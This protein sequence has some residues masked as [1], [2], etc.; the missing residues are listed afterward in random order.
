MVPFP[1]M[2]GMR[3][4]IR[5]GKKCEPAAPAVNFSGIDRALAKLEC[6]A[7]ETQPA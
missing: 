7:L 1:E 3:E 6:E 4:C 2:H 5:S